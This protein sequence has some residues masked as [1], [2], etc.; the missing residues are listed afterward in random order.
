[1][2]ER[3]AAINLW[4]LAAMLHDDD[5]YYGRRRDAPARLRDAADALGWPDDMAS[6]FEDVTGDKR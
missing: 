2:T 4:Y 1:M 6:V 5:S 3:E